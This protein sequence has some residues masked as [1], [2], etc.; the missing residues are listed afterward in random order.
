MGKDKHFSVLIKSGHVL[1]CFCLCCLFL[2]ESIRGKTGKY[3]SRKNEPF[4]SICI[5]FT[6]NAVECIQNPTA[7]NRA[8]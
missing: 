8:I 7:T 4:Y 6:T 1:Y 2:F 3:N 5:I